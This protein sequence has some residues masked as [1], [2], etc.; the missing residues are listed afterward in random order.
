M[1]DFGSFFD[2]LGSQNRSKIAPRALPEPPGDLPERTPHRK[3][4]DGPKRKR[5][6]L[7]FTPRKGSWTR[8]GGPGDHF[9]H[10]F[11]FNNIKSLSHGCSKKRHDSLYI[12]SFLPPRCLTIAAERPIAIENCLP[13]ACIPN[14]SFDYP[15]A[16]RRPGRS[17]MN[18]PSGLWHGLGVSNLAV[19]LYRNPC[20]KSN[21][22]QCNLMR[23]FNPPRRPV[24][25]DHWIISF[26]QPL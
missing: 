22:M 5:K 25:Q 7:D 16:A 6:W 9:S 13:H 15:H 20:R 14:R 26:L 2:P 3:N 17:P 12:W 24:Q 10:N 23:I 21:C 8:S 11:A 18:P 19:Y 1:L 4:S